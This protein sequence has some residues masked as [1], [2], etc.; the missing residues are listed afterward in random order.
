M[1]DNV[2]DWPV[3]RFLQVIFCTILII[4]FVACS[5]SP[6]PAAASAE[7]S[8]SLGAAGGTVEVTNPSSPIGW[9]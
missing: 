2:F 8:E 9:S 4:I 5:P 6:S 7:A 1:K 3:C